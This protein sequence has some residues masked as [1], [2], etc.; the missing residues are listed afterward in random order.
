MVELLDFLL[1]ALTL[2]FK[3]VVGGGLCIIVLLAIAFFTLGCYYLFM[4]AM[5]RVF[6]KLDRKKKRVADEH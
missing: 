5:E 4:E 6:E 3:A 2:T 1:F